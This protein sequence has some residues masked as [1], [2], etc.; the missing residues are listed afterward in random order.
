MVFQ[1]ITFG[2]TIYGYGFW[3]EPWAAEFG[4]SRGQIM[5]GITLMNAASAIMS[6]FVGRALDKYSIRWIVCFGA[7]ALAAGFLVIST[8]TG[9]W[10]ILASYMLLISIAVVL[11]GPL[12]ASTLVAKWFTHGRGRAIGFSSVGTSLGGFIMPMVIGYMLIEYGWRQAH[13]YLAFIALILIVPLT[14]WIVRNSPEDKGIAPEPPPDD[15]GRVVADM[16]DQPWTTATVLRDRTFW[17]LTASLGLMMMPFSGTIPNLVPYAL[18]AGI[19]VA[20]A[21]VMMTL[22]AGGGIVS[23]IIMGSLADRVDLRYLVWANNVLLGTPL[24]LLMGEPDFTGLLVISALLG[25]STGG[26]T[27]L[28]GAAIGTHF[29]P[30]AFGRVFGLYNPFTLGFALMGPPLMGYLFDSTGSYDLSLQIFVGMIV[31][32]AI[33]TLFL[34]I[35]PTS[36]DRDAG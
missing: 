18:E 24:V 19:S 35:G 15:P 34:R 30:S 23:K 32:S 31:G 8:A 7:V 14:L 16:D 33:V 28:V 10:T 29:G 11:V 5:M 22:L 20:D 3:V 2:M 12:S 4:A 36:S 26:F 27:P 17:I 9:I 25:L 1:S 13:V 6:P 21:A